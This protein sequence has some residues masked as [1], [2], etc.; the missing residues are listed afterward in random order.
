MNDGEKG[1]VKFNKYHIDLIITDLKMPKLGGLELIEKIRNSKHTN[2]DIS[3]IIISAYEDTKVLRS[4]IKYDVQGF[5]VKPVVFSKLT[6]AIDK[7]KNK[8]LQKRVK[9]TTIKKLN[10][11]D[12]LEYGEHRLI[13]HLD[14]N[15]SAIVI[16]I[17]INEFKYLT[18]L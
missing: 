9:K 12:N 2:A 16:F 11:N 3:T 5:I 14:A 13:D 17:K 6:Q 4:S 7:V 10:R 1:L 18:Y 8:S 15:D